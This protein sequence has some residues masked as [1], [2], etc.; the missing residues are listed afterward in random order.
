M[1]LAAGVKIG[2]EVAILGT[3]DHTQECMQR[4][5]ELS[6]VAY[7]W[8]LMGHTAAR[9]VHF[10]MQGK[11]LGRCP[12][13]LHGHRTSQ[14]RRALADDPLV[15]RAISWMQ[16]NLPGRQPVQQLCEV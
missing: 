11:Q 1:C 10:W 13:A 12:A 15:A 8:G 14:H 6:S 5:P 4:E 16:Q 7:P 9:H 3:G 2:E